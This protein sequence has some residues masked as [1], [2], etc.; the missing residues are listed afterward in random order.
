MISDHSVSAEQHGRR[1]PRKAGQQGADCLCYKQSMNSLDQRCGQDV[2]IL[3]LLRECRGTVRIRQANR[4]RRCRRRDPNR[5]G[6]KPSTPSRAV[7]GVRNLAG[8]A[9][10]LLQRKPAGHP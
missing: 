8:R 2:E 9:L 10:P 7:P 1:V 6:G 5:F 3:L 4:S